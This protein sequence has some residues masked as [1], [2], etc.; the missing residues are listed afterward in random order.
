[1]FTA[2]YFNPRYFTTDYWSKTGLDPIPVAPP[3]DVTVKSPTVTFRKIN[4]SALVQQLEGPEPKYPVYTF[5]ST[6]KF[7]RPEHPG[8]EYRWLDDQEDF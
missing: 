4:A 8:N 6:R 2:S 5:G 7:E 3:V 1:M